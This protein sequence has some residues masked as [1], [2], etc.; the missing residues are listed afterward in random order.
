[1]GSPFI[2]EIRLFAGNFA[3]L[4]WHFCDG[5]LVPIADNPTLFQLIGTTYGGDGVQTFALPDMRSSVPVHWGTGGGGTYVTGQ[6][7]GSETVTLLTQQIPSHTHQ[8]A[9]SNTGPA[10]SP[11]G[12]LP[13]VANS[14]A[15]TVHVYGPAAAQSTTL[16]PLSLTMDGS[17]LPHNNLQPY[18]AVSFIISLFGIFPSQQ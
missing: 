14:A 17:S 10:L 3:P 5:A 18:L 7:A 11:Q 13:A 8:M 1:M 4:N 9:S 16:N 15:G 6:R 12:N 2:G